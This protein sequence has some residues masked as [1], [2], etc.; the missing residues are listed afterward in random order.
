MIYLE[1][2]PAPPLGNFVEILWY[3][4]DYRA[5][6]RH[7]AV[8]PTGSTALILPLQQQSTTMPALVAGVHTGYVVID[9]AALDSLLGVHFRPAGAFAFLGGAPV[10]EF[11]NQDVPLEAV[12]TRGEVADLRE[13]AALAATPACK[14]KVL[15]AALLARLAAGPSQESPSAVSYAVNRLERAPHIETVGSVADQTGLSTRRL[16]ELFHR[17]VGIAPKVFCRIKRFRL[18]VERMNAGSEIRWADLAADCGFYDQSHF[19]REFRDFSGMN[20]NEYRAGRSAW[21]GHVIL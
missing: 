14:F 19:L 8:L 10:E 3:C 15:E 16:G 7:E 9:T 18:A 6:H 20:P 13:R 11:R 2:R 5:T 12:W 17:H 21:N 4:A 1:H